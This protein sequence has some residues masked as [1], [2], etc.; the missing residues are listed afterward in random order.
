MHTTVIFLHLNKYL[1]FPN[2]DVLKQSFL[3][4]LAEP[5]TIDVLVLGRDQG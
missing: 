4:S 2:V 3:G 5:K 1:N